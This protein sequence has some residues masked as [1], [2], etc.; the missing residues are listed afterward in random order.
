MSD[1][2]K[3]HFYGDDCDPPHIPP[4]PEGI[5]GE[6]WVAHRVDARTSVMVNHVCGRI[7][8]HEGAH[9]CACGAESA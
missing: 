9:L 4:K 6:W 5:C 8:H 1:E 3:T 2:G 7:M